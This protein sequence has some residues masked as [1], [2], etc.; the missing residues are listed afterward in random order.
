ME[1]NVRF[2]SEYLR[3][4]TKFIVPVYQ[5]N[6][7]WKKENCRR[8]IED[9][10]SLEEENKETHFFGSIVVKPGDYSQDII[11]IDGQQRLTT[12]SLL[13]LAMKNWME[14]NEIKGERINPTNIN[15]L[16]LVDSFSR[17]VDKFK[18]KSN[19]RDYQAYKK[20]FN[21]E[22][23][24][25]KNSNITMNYEFLYS[26]LESLPI[27]LDQLMNSIQKLQVMVVNLNS[28][29]DDPQLI[30]ESLNSTGVDLTDADKIR[31]YLL[32]NEK[33][34][35][36]NFLFENYWEPIEE[37][38]HFQLSSFF[39][40]YLTIKNGKYPNI[41]KV[42]EAFTDFY[43]DSCIEKKEFFDE[44]SSYSYAYKQILDTATGVKQI[45]EILNR[46]NEL[47]VTV[48]RPFLMAILHDYNQNELSSKEV[49][50][51]FRVLET[52][53]VRRMITKLP[54]NALN[55]IISVLYRDMKRMLAKEENQGI[56][57]SDVINYLLMSKTNTG[58]F[59][60]DEEVRENLSSRDLYNANSV[61]RTYLFERLEN[62]D[63]FEALQI[64]D[65]IKNQEYSIEHI[66]PQRLSRQWID[67][68]G[69][70]YK[71]IHDTY[72]HSIG[73]LTITGY[74]SKYSNKSFGE[75]QTM[76]KGFKDSHFVN[77]NR[78]TAN[79]PNWGEKEI[80]E[81]TEDLIQT[82]LNIW[83][84]PQTE[85]IPSYEEKSMIIYDGEQH[86]TNYQIKGYSFISDEYQP[87]SSWKDFYVNIIKQLADIN[88]NP[89]MDLSK[90]ESQS[91]LEGM[92]SDS[93]NAV[94]SEI[95]PG[96][97]VFSSLSNWRKM[98]YIKQLLELYQI[99]YDTLMIDAVLYESKTDVTEVS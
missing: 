74:N 59:P 70:D 66:M 4:G 83:P 93:P 24:F 52:Y 90:I 96:L 65:G 91:G 82:A 21:D 10:I 14:K 51:I 9:L 85:F 62:Y 6:Y 31:N 22:K 72:L 49:T 28:P 88:L 32:M 81:R 47:Q 89:L 61:F 46:F 57:P 50:K 55:K 15:D 36:Q 40:D 25:I 19:P 37:R 56:V 23:F 2:L 67:D 34:D 44:L 63:H 18:L 12:T 8:L 45:N 92:F 53:I 80:L 99:E 68:L 75:K 35:S 42:Y 1:G 69:P 86:F 27:N 16:F 78:L 77:L 64:Y 98:N 95:L 87:I 76:E 97:Y 84:Y 94:N 79:V 43:Q 3:G 41:S 5:R 39:R 33:Q 60:I 73:N 7:D 54:S 71:R 38:T 30:F 29:N 17:D 20:L 26:M 58:K 48:V 13:L 11:V